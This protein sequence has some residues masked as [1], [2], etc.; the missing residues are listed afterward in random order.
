[1]VVMMMMIMVPDVSCSKLMSYESFSREAM[2]LVH[3]SLLALVEAA[4]DGVVVAAV[5]DRPLPR[6]PAV[7]SALQ[8]PEQRVKGVL[9]ATLAHEAH[10]ALVVLGVEEGGKKVEAAAACGGGGERGVIGSRVH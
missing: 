6:L 4:L 7:L 3:R 5:A 10:Q 8:D 1:M 2:G 9:V